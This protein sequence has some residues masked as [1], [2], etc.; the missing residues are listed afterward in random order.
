MIHVYHQ[1]L[2]YLPR[3]CVV[4]IRTSWFTGGHSLMM[5][6][7]LSAGA[8]VTVCADHRAT[9]VSSIETK[10]KVNCCFGAIFLQSF[11]QAH[12]WNFEVLCEKQGW[13]LVL[14]SEV[15]DSGSESFGSKSN[16]TCNQR[17]QEVVC[18]IWTGQWIFSDIN[19]HDNCVRWR[20]KRS[21]T[22]K[23]MMRCSHFMRRQCKRKMNF[24]KG[25]N[26][27]FVALQLSMNK[28]KRMESHAP[29]LTW[30]N[31][32]DSFWSQDLWNKKL[33][34]IK[35]LQWHGN[36]SLLFNRECTEQKDAWNAAFFLFLKTDLQMF[37]WSGA[38]GI[39][40]ASFAVW[41]QTVCPT[42][43]Q[44]HPMTR[45]ILIDS[46]GLHCGWWMIQP[47]L[48][49]WPGEQFVPTQKIFSNCNSRAGASNEF[50]KNQRKCLGVRASRG[51]VHK[52]NTVKVWL[53]AL[54]RKWRLMHEH[55]KQE[56]VPMM[57]GWAVWL[58]SA[59]GPH[60]SHCHQKTFPK[61]ESKVL[62]CWKFAEPEDFYLGRCIDALVSSADFIMGS[63]T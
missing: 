53:N 63:G 1:C 5:V 38:L 4:H 2:W 21:K 27:D 50:E 42:S 6:M 46:M 34:P 10:E 57:P 51:E 59:V 20:P 8:D 60:W 28:F 56:P 39:L 44:S 15:R 3:L 47:R 9:R 58:L 11:P 12:H 17:P 45:H 35:L 25:L 31:P 30:E 24:Q 48:T 61:E 37:F 41:V 52:A 33:C 14:D 23:K 49:K 32:M 7:L 62:I 29:T 22:Q 43:V 40:I 54:F 55:E 26:V 19:V 13:V 36:F 18:A 16:K